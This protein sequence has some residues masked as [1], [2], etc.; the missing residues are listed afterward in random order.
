MAEADIPTGFRALLGR[1]RG[2]FASVPQH[3]RRLRGRN[4][5]VAGGVGAAVLAALVF[6]A[7]PRGPEAQTERAVLSGKALFAELVLQQPGVARS[8]RVDEGEQRGT[9]TNLIVVP[10]A[11]WDELSA[12]Q[13]N[14]L[15]AWLNAVGGRW[16][17]RVGVG[18]KDGQRVLDAEAVITSRD[19]NQ[20][21]R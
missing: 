20:Q 19:W 17:I 7:I 13:R 21:L 12:G 3:L 16:E 6:A 4:A 8:S 9:G 11:A 14:S 10:Q 5:A 2:W 18:S 15:G 1:L